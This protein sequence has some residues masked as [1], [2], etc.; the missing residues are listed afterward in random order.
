MDSFEHLDVKVIAHCMP[1]SAQDLL[2]AGLPLPPGMEP[3]PTPP[4]P[5]RCRRLQWAAR[6]AVQQARERV[7]FWIAGYEPDDEWR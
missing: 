7:G 2:D 5:S 4:R 1:V 3:P 6:A